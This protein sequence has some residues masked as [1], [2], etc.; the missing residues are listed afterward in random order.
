MW[1]EGVLGEFR[2]LR[3]PSGPLKRLGRFRGFFRGFAD[4][5]LRQE[6]SKRPRTG[7]AGY[8]SCTIVRDCAAK[9][10]RQPG[11]CRNL[12]PSPGT[13]PPVWGFAGGA[14][15]RHHGPSAVRPRIPLPRL[16][17]P[18]PL[19]LASQRHWD[20]R[21][22]GPPSCNRRRPGP[23]PVSLRPF[24]RSPDPSGAAFRGS[25]PILERACSGQPRHPFWRIAGRGRSTSTTPGSLCNGVSISIQIPR[26]MPSL[27]AGRKRASFA[28]RTAAQSSDDRT[29]LR[30]LRP[31][32]PSEGS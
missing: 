12:S 28:A 11:S 14:R 22:H 3:P 15:R 2:G 25:V 1:Q 24:L 17:G 7:Y 5:P 10:G 32:R 8:D 27:E 9:C 21:A 16:H 26:G 30:H 4:P 6:A 29:P 13:S 19:P 23:G 31:G 18:A 20:R